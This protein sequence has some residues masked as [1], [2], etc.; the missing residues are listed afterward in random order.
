MRL[1]AAMHHGL[2]K[3]L[4]RRRRSDPPGQGPRHRH[5]DM[6]EVR[7][8]SRKITATLASTGTPAFFVHPGEASHGDL[9]MITSDDVIMALLSWSAETTE[10]KNLIDYSRRFRI[11]L[12]AITAAAEQHSWQVRRRGADA[13]A[14]PRGLPAQRLAPTIVVTDA[15]CDRATRSRWA[16]G[17]RRGF[18][19]V[20]FGLLHPGSRLGALLK[21]TRDVMTSGRPRC[22]SLHLGTKMSRRGACKC[23][24]RASAASG[25]PRRDSKIAWA[26]SPTA[27]FAATWATDLLSARV[28]DVTT[29]PMGRSARST[30]QRDA[31]NP[32]LRPR[33]L[34]LFVVDSG[35]P[36]GIVHIRDLLR[37]GAA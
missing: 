4:H 31:R 22:H 15:A 11:G 27:T 2:G 29:T 12:V 21:F 17:S 10:L 34:R 35:R 37:A 6:G 3:A 5:P 33:S 9:G 16:V 8:V 36:I 7:Y 20:D 25:S 23:L 19:A 28:D 13:A 24:P 26:S 14:D 1:V 32:Q 18:T 30:R